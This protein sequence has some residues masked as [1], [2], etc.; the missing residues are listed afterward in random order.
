MRLPLPAD[1]EL[2][3]KKLDAKVRNQVRKGEKSDL[4]V[5]WGGADRLDPFYAVLSR[6]MR[7]LGTPVYGRRLFERI[8]TTFPG[9]AELCV[10]TLPAERSRVAA[11]LL[12]HGPGVTEVPTA[13]SLREF[14][15]TCCNMLMY[16]HL[17]DRAVARGQAVFDFGR[18]TAGRADVQVQEAVG[19]GAVPGDV[20]VLRPPRRGRR[21]AAGQPQVPA[22]DPRSGSGCRWA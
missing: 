16:R 1:P 19:G 3:W 18:S 14:N 15:A 20:A 2:L 11:A 7:D 13:S 6:N 5:D 22:A 9:A 8:L 10:V 17:L 4:T 12:L 21:D